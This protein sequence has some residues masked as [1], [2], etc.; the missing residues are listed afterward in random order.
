[1]T[2]ALSRLRAEHPLTQ[3]RWSLR[4]IR[5]AASQRAKSASCTRAA[6]KADRKAT[7]SQQEGSLAFFKLK[8]SKAGALNSSTVRTPREKKKVCHRAQI[9]TTN[10]TSLGLRAE[11]QLSCS[12]P[13]RV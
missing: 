10:K 1:M 7:P 8:Q 3:G 5:V 4:W 6:D 9:A 13:G 2:S 11:S 12:H